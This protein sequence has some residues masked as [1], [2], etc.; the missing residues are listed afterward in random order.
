LQKTSAE[1]SEDTRAE[2]QQKQG[3]AEVSGGTSSE[4]NLGDGAAG[5]IAKGR[6]QGRAPGA[7]G[8]A[9]VYRQHHAE[10]AGLEDGSDLGHQVIGVHLVDRVPTQLDARVAETA[11]AAQAFCRQSSSEVSGVKAPSLP[12]ISNGAQTDRQLQ[13]PAETPC[14][15]RIQTCKPG[16]SH[17][18]HD[19]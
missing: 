15:K 2:E 5:G 18:P 16:T 10:L 1:V 19:L 7:G 12:T 11:A 8:V 4:A 3:T 17:A 6:L 14:K 9:D 13:L